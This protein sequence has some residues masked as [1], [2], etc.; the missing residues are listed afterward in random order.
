MFDKLRKAFSGTISNI[1][2]KEITEKDLD[3]NLFDLQ[4]A[5]LESDVAQEVIDEISSKLKK[6]LLGFSIEKGQTAHDIIANKFQNT[7]DEILSK[8]NNVD[9]IG[10]I[11]QKRENKNGPFVIV[12]LGINGTG[13]TTTV[14]KV[15]NMLHKNDISVV[16]AAADT[17]R[18][19]AIEQLS[20]HAKRLS[21]KIITQRYGADPSA[22]AR[23][24]IDYA[25]KHRIDAVLVDTA[26]RMQTAKNLMDEISKIVKV[27]K[28][29]MKIFVG[30]SLAGNDTINQAREFFSYTDFDGAIL[31]KTDA[32]AKGGAVISISFITAKPI[33]F[34]GMGQG[35]D[36]M[37]PFNKESF[38]N[39]LFS[40]SSNSYD[41]NITENQ[42]SKII[43]DNNKHNKKI[44]S[45]N[46]N[47]E[48]EDIPIALNNELTEDISEST[49]PVI[50][51]M[52]QPLEIN[53]FNDENIS[54]VLNNSDESSNMQ[55][56]KQISDS[57]GITSSIVNK[58][59]PLLLS[60]QQQQQQP[61]LNDRIKNTE[62]Q[63]LS[64][65]L[66]SNNKNI[67][68]ENKLHE[69][70]AE[71]HIV[72]E[73]ETKKETKKGGFFSSLFKRKKE[74][75]KS[76]KMLFSEREK[77]EKE[78]LDST[79]TNDDEDFISQNNN[80]NDPKILAENKKPSITDNKKDNDDIIYLSDDDIEDLVK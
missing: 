15:A 20:E 47:R 46:Y 70:K 30:D 80:S 10:K 29:D 13:K 33:M 45:K 38:L 58:K 22:V 5:L 62:S 77:I 7:I 25:R 63:K 2:K 44:Y 34:L 71:F 49:S 76:T 60:D 59:D 26:G 18:A 35:Y 11:I 72:E 39:S 52:I 68:I 69:K 55:T 48:E 54:K 8:S 74:D 40:T 21:L 9:L 28:P 66:E 42:T 3:N 19:G 79:N 53:S 17:H 41:D 51:D 75:E 12:F 67:V 23:D 57:E 1:I 4:I 73:S 24:A 36:D 37:I 61:D 50:K 27:T 31:T 32:D 78:H 43:I 14:A 65:T 6:E 56:E 16:L 64:K